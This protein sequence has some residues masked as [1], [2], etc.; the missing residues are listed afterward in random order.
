MVG[1]SEPTEPVPLQHCDR[2]HQE[3]YC[4]WW[5]KWSLE[6]VD[7][8]QARH[9]WVGRNVAELRRVYEHVVKRCIVGK[10]KK[11]RL[12]HHLPRSNEK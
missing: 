5:M 2:Q 8:D 10:K 11:L 7:R 1:G 4:L 12:S 9:G 3:V 6:E